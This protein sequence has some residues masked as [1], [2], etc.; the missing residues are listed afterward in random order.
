MNDIKL[1]GTDPNYKIIE[2][3]IGEGGSVSDSV[4]EDD[5]NHL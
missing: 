5:F 3:S 1:F 4:E 2:K